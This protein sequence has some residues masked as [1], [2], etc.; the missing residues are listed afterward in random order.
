MQGALLLF[1]LV[2]AGVLLSGY[3]N[4]TW[5]TL[6]GSLLGRT[7]GIL[8]GFTAAAGSGSDCTCR[9]TCGPVR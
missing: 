9:P 1:G 5:A 8:A 2:N 3:G 4:G 6:L 7:L